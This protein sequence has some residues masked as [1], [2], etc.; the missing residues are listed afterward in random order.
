MDEFKR[1]Y[2]NN[3]TV[4][5]AMPYFWEHFEKENYSIWRGDYKY[6]NELT[7]V[8]MTCNLVGGKDCI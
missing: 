4:T 1:T 5:V 7:Q 8:F 2:S 3:D 6:N